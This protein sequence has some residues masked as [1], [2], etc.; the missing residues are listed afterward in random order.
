MN[1]AELRAKL[2][3]LELLATKMADQ[4]QS[5]IA[6]SIRDIARDMR[7]TFLEMPNIEME[8]H[9][10]GDKSTFKVGEHIDCVSV[11]TL[12]EDGRLA[13]DGIKFTTWLSRLTDKGRISNG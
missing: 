6:E 12:F 5:V 10:T 4:S 1:K 8:Q 13:S 9:N 7:L 3:L 2:A 11:V